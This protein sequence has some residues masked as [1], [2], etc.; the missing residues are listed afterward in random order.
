METFMR[1]VPNRRAWLAWASAAS[2]TLLAPRG[3]WAEIYLS[4]PVRVVASVAA[5]RPADALLRAMCEEVGKATR[6]EFFVENKPGVGGVVAANAVRASVPDGNTLFLGGSSM[7]LGGVQRGNANPFS[8]LTPVAQLMIEPTALGVR[9]ELEIRSVAD[10]IQFAREQP[11]KFSYATAG[12]GS[13]AH[14]MMEL[15]ARR[16]GVKLLHVPYSKQTDPVMAAITDVLGGRL[17]AVFTPFFSLL[18]H[19]EQGKISLVGMTGGQRT[20][21]APNVP[22]FVESGYPELAATVWFGLFAPWTTSS[23]TVEKIAADFSRAGRE[24]KVQEMARAL[25]LEV[26][27]TDPKQFGELCDREREDWRRVIDQTGIKP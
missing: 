24:P 11:G 20:S 27:V 23:E 6:T 16:A 4:R 12:V 26:A 8:G 21:V 3:A 5:G 1:S 22:T 19:A 15:L 14:Y 10:L 9:S 13:Y 17:D 2:T 7:M 18:P 25:A